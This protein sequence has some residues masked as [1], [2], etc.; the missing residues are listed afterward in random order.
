MC[1]SGGVVDGGRGCA[2]DRK[3]KGTFDCSAFSV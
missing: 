3:G 1:H 2:C